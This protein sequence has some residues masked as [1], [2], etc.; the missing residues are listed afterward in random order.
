MALTLIE[1]ST[2]LPVTVDDIK[3][4]SRISS[5]TVQAQ[6][7][8]SLDNL[9]LTTSDIQAQ[10]YTGEDAKLEDFIA[11]VIDHIETTENLDLRETTWKLTLPRFGRSIVIPRHPLVSVDEITYY[12]TA[13][14]QQTLAETDYTVLDSTFSLA[15]V[16]PVT[17]WPIVYP[18][19]DAVQIT[20]T[21]GYE[22]LPPSIF[23]AVCLAAATWNEWRED[24]VDRSLS[25]IALGFDRLIAG[26]RVE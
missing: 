9:P 20:F 10:Q 3:L 12:D 22:E 7:F 18:R 17:S 26:A 5:P 24:E 23:Q 21:S 16:Y 15:K 19:V 2:D 13:G 8:V 14:E 11:G 1:K 25:R 4:H 6:G